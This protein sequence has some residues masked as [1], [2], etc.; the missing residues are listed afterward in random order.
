VHAAEERLRAEAAHQRAE[1]REL[2]RFLR[3]TTTCR[4]WR[5]IIEAG[6]VDVKLCEA[7]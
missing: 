5:G 1:D 3:H 7:L 2:P 4:R 6:T